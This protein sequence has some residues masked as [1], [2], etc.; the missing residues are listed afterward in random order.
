MHLCPSRFVSHF[1]K[2]RKVFTPYNHFQFNNLLARH[3]SSL[4]NPKVCCFLGSSCMTLIDAAKNLLKF[5][6]LIYSPTIN[7][8]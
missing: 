7:L 3:V 6:G 4:F 1:P 5:L 8:C 2:C